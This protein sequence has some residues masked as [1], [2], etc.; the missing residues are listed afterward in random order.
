MEW[1]DQAVELAKAWG[2][3]WAMVF[4]QQWVIWQLT[5]KHAASMEKS[6]QT[7]QDV[8]AALAG[9]TVLVERIDR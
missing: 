2:P 3:L 1:L 5:Q 6:A 9:L 4:W 8:A 7:A